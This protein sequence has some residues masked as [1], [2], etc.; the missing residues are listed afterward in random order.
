MHCFLQVIADGGGVQHGHGV[1]G[2]G[3]D[4]GNDVHF[5][6]TELAHAE[7]RSI[8]GEH[9]VGPF[10]LAGDKENGSGIEPGAGKPGDGVSSAG[11]V[12]TNAT[13]R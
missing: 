4:N 12:V 8:G 6:H 7:G 2:E 1:L 13:P 10:H 9:A 11:P 5:L 3:F